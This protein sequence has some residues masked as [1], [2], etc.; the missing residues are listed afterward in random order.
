VVIGDVTG[1]GMA[2][3]FLMATAQLLVRMTLTRWQDPARC[4]R[5]VN[6]Q[7]CTQGFRGQFVTMLVMVLDPADHTV[8][9]AT[10]GHPGPLIDRAGEIESLDLEP[11]LVLGVDAGEMYRSESFILEPGASVLLYTD[12]VVEAER[13]DGQQFGVQGLIASL[14]SASIT[15]PEARI[16]AVLQGV[17]RFRGRRE[18]LDDVTLVGVRMAPAGERAGSGERGGSAS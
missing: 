15:T 8:E 17:E 11:Q 16:R 6:Q 13:E 9:I 5:E 1:H 10:A 4:L 18:L 14:T 3:A 12:G 7:V 2:A